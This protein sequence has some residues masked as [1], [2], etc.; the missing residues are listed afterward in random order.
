MAIQNNQNEKQPAQQQAG[1]QGQQ[2]PQQAGSQVNTNKT[3]QGSQVNQKPVQQQPA[4]A[5]QSSQQNWQKD[6][7]MDR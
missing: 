7:D 4:K 3:Q 6:K 1:Q 5:G 2:R